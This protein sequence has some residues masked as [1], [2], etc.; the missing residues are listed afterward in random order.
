MREAENELIKLLNRKNAL[1][2]DFLISSDPYVFE[3]IIGQMY[4]ELGYKVKQTPKSNDKGKDLIMTK[5]GKKYIVEC[6]RYSPTNLIGRPEIQKFYGACIEENVEKGFFVTTSD[7]T[8]SAKSYPND[9]A[10]KIQLVNGL[11]LIKLMEE[12]YPLNVE[13]DKYELV[14]GQC[15][16]IVQFELNGDLEKKCKSNHLVKSNIEDIKKGIFQTS[17]FVYLD[18]K[19][20]ICSSKMRKIK[21][22]YHKNSYFWG[23]SK[24]PKCTGVVR[25]ND[26][27]PT[28]LMDLN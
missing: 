4:E 14:C 26:N 27:L 6:K 8:S 5:G 19:C 17:S 3:K 25:K 10:N 20:P 18:P 12:A 1:K 21:S 22:K 15:G 13:N 16:D 23:C 7:F 11:S 24:Y 2:L 28:N 9:I